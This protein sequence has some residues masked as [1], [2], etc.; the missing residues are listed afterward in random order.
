MATSFPCES[1]LTES[2]GAYRSTLLL[3]HIVQ[4]AVLFN[5]GTWNG[6]L[7]E[8]TPS[9]Y[10]EE[11]GETLPSAVRALFECLAESRETHL[12]TIRS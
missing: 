10:S 4:R 6:M 11:D 1:D 7:A 2:D 5:F 3:D 12:D 9:L 8:P